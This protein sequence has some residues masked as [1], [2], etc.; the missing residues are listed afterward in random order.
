[1][2]KLE[3]TLKRITGRATTTGAT[4]YTVPAGGSITI[5]GLRA[6]NGDAS[7]NHTFHAKVAGM[8][9]CGI[10]TDLPIGSAIDVLVGSKVVALP[11]DTVQ[12]FADA[13]SVVDVYVS[14][15]EQIPVVE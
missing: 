8:L 2:A 12:V 13:N 1:M 6:A 5:I 7:N 11:G 4:L 3:S 9:V 15:L 14:Y 10:N